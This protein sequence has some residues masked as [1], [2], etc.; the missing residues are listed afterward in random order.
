MGR[1]QRYFYA[2][3]IQTTSVLGWMYFNRTSV[4]QEG[5]TDRMQEVVASA[6]QSSGGA[7]QESTVQQDQTVTGTD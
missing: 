5:R 1:K 3:K 7:F 4:K 6:Q 2:C